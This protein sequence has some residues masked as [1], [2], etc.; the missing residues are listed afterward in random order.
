VVKDNLDTYGCDIKTSI[1]DINESSFDIQGM[2]LE[3]LV[4]FNFKPFTQ[5]Q[6]AITDENRRSS[7]NTAYVLINNVIPGSN[8]QG[9]T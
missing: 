4:H 5:I 3:D 7:K 8:N 6:T 9:L 2:N 1:D